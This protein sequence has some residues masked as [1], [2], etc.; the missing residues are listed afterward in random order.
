MARR[1]DADKRRRIL[2]EAKRVFAEDGFERTS[3]GTVA[4]RVGIPVGS[5]YT[6]FDSK[7]TLLQ[8][9]VGE[10]WA[11]FASSLE[12]GLAVARPVSGSAGNAAD[13]ALAKLAFL[14]LR[15]FPTLLNDVDLIA[16]LLAQADRSALLAE[17]LEYLASLIAAIITE[18]HGSRTE[19][20]E[21]I[22]AVPELKAGIAVMLLGSLETVR[23]I[24][25][26]EIG[27]TIADVS[28]FLVATV[29]AALGCSLP[30]D[31]RLA[32]A[33]LGAERGEG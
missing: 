14:V 7:G 22:A 25:R 17:K 32:N 16:I 20:G 19:G 10:G 11:E 28:A 12:Q 33:G 6:Y 2:D 18:Y 30:R 13:E 5:L 15:A 1:K 31:L 24:G 26:A 21:S 3:M 9:I 23:L 27:L 8:A 29:E 4:E